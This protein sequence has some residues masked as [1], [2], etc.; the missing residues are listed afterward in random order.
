MRER[1]RERERDNKTEIK[2][3]IKKN[4]STKFY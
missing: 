4:T 1:E 3:I 2:N